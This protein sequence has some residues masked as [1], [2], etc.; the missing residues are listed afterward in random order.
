MLTL[1]NIFEQVKNN[2]GV[3][4]YVFHFTYGL[5]IYY[6]LLKHEAYYQ[7]M[8]QFHFIIMWYISVNNLPVN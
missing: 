6:R 2:K 5:Q 3:R 4:Q 8:R 7:A 1:A